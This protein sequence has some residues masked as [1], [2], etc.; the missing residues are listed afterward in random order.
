MFLYIFLNMFYLFSN[1]VYADYIYIFNSVSMLILNIFRFS[2]HT[3][4]IYFLIQCKGTKN[5]AHNKMYKGFR[6]K[7]THKI[8]IGHE[9]GITNRRKSGTKHGIMF[10]L[11]PTLYTMHCISLSISNMRFLLSSFEYF[12]LLHCYIVTC[13]ISTFLLFLTRSRKKREKNSIIY[14]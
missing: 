2:F 6:C 3:D 7:N 1:C 14:I 5:L 10:E 9:S 12:I 13:H 4:F 11:K 8:C